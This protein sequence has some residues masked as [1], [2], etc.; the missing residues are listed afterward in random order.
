MVHSLTRFRPGGHMILHESPDSVAAV[1]LEF[2][3]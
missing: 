2:L 3:R 1:L